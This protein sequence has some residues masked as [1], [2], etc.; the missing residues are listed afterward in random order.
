MTTEELKAEAAAIARAFREAPSVPAEL[1]KRFIAVRAALFGRGVFNPV[2][3][4]FDSAT[5]TRASSEEIAAQLDALATS[6]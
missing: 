5:V 1:R 4:R 3:A 2:L 6:L